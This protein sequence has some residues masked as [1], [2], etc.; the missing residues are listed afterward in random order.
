MRI[1]LMIA[2]VL[3]VC[4]ALGCSGPNSPDRL[5]AA[6]PY[7][8]ELEWP[9]NLDMMFAFDPTGFQPSD[10]ERDW[11]SRSG[12]IEV[13]GAATLI[14]GGVNDQERSVR[15]LRWSTAGSECAGEFL[16]QWTC[17][18]LGS[19]NLGATAP[20]SGNFGVTWSP[21][22]LDAIEVLVNSVPAG[23]ASVVVETESGLRVGS[24][25]VRGTAWLA[26]P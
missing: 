5:A 20:G 11:L 26:Y 17:F 8:P 9:V 10:E 2:Q 16:G 25:V 12:A 18:E 1:R 3:F 7:T 6:P 21:G 24:N 19:E 4:V 13:R 14:D 22:Q 23:S 15:L